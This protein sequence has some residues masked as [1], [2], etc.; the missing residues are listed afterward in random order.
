MVESLF[1]GLASGSFWFGAVIGFLVYRTLKH[2]A[3]AA[4]KD[5]ATVVGAVGGGV[6]VK[7]FP[8]GS[9]RFDSYAIG[10]AAGVFL[11]LYLSLVI[12]LIFGAKTSNDLLGDD[13]KNR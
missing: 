11:Y 10:L 5:I 3:N 4:A 7:L 9:E 1:A 8:A 13:T 2:S 6:V 12:G